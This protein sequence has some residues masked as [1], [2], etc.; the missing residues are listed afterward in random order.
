MLADL[1]LRDGRRV[2]AFDLFGDL[3]LRRSA[4]RVVTRRGLPALVDA[5][6]A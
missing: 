2:V 4:D 6:V 5:A 1:A 3:D